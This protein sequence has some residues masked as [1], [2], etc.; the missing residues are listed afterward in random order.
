MSPLLISLLTALL[1]SVINFFLG[2]GLAYLVMNMKRG[3]SL[4]DGFLT[5]SMV[6]PPTVVGF[7]LL[8]IFGKNSIIGRALGSLG[9]SIIFTPTAAVISAIVVSLPIM[10]RTSL[11]AFEQVNEDILFAAK[12]LGIS[13]MKIFWK[14]LLPL[15]VPG[16]LSGLILTFARALGEFGATIMIAGNIPGKTQTMSTAIYSA[17]QAGNRLLAFK[18]SITIVIISFSSMILANSLSQKLF[19]EN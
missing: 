1:A 2:I 19:R 7:F 4:V 3:R 10:Y 16:V 13:K 12:T 11:G 6:L 5:L 14:I 17:V 15:S 8:I 18:W 9:I